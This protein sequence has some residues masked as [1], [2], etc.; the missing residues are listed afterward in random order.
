MNDLLRPA[1]YQS[2][3]EIVP[4]RPQARA[5]IHAD[6]VGPVCESGDFLARNREIPTYCP[7]TCW[8]FAQP[9]PMAS[10]RPPTTTPAREPPKS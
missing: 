10:C 2:H 1:L 5:I 3:H 8:P 9:E 4:V 6:V 7:G